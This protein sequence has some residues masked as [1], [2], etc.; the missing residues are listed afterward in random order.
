MKRTA[1]AITLVFPLL[2]SSIARSLL[3]NVANAQSMA[4]Y[5][6][7]PFIT[8]NSPEQFEVCTTDTVTFSFS[9]KLSPNKA[10]FQPEVYELV[11][12]HEVWFEADWQQNKTY[13]DQDNNIYLEP[14]VLLKPCKELIFSSN[15]ENIPI[16]DRNI[17]IYATEEIPGNPDPWYHTTYQI[18]LFTVNA[19]NEETTSET[20]T[21]NDEPVPTTL[22]IATSGIIAIVGISSIIYFKKRKRSTNGNSA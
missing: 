20:N 5:P 13:I 21:Y 16:G 19:T 17:T 8:V 12:L 2:L 9:M 18:V 1:L 7:L 3:S 14:K 4:W 15:L 6:S 22:V 11:N 10:Y